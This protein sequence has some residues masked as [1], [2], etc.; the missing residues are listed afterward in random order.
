MHLLKEIR[1]VE[2]KLESKRSVVTFLQIDFE[3]EL[4]S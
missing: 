1:L 3:S 4:T 2:K